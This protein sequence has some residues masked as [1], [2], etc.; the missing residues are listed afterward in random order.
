[1]CDL[2]ILEVVHG[3]LTPAYEECC[4]RSTAATRERTA[5]RDRAVA[6]AG[7]LD[8]SPLG[9]GDDGAEHVVV[10]AVAGGP[11][12]AAGA[13]AATPVDA[14]S[15]A[16]RNAAHR[17]RALQWIRCEMAPHQ[18]VGATADLPTPPKPVASYDAE[19]LAP[20]IRRVGA[21]PTS[22]G[23]TSSQSRR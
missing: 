5:R 19:A 12:L 11:D 3:L 6:G 13:D 7:G 22:Y 2:S 21:S 17:Q 1:M 14:S 20:C 18:R 8:A 4:R 23:S 15:Y 10:E 9:D 16:E